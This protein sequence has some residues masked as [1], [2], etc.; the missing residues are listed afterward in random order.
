MGWLFGTV[1]TDFLPLKHLNCVLGLAGFGRG[2]AGA[3]PEPLQGHL[4]SEAL[5]DPSVT[6]PYG[7]SVS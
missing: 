6:S 5:T 4:Q 1:F 2:D 3:C 7:Q